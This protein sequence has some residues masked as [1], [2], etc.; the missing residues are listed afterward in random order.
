MHD[1]WFSLLPFLIVIPIAIWTKQVLPGLIAG[2]LLGS[3]LAEPTL[4]GGINQMLDC[5]LVNLAKKNNLL[6]II[7]LY[8]FSGLIGMITVAGGIKG[9]AESLVKRIQTRKGSLILTWASTIGTF[10]SPNLRVVTVTPVM[11]AV[12]NRVKMSAQELGFVI[13]TTANPLIALIP[14]ATAFVGY[15]TSVIQMSLEHEG[16]KQDAYALYMQSIPFNFFSIVMLLVG[17]YLSFFHHSKDV[18]IPLKDTESE[19]TDWLDCH[20]AVAKNL[21]SKPFNLIAPLILVIVLSF[22]L[23]WWDGHTK[24]AGF[25]QAF[26]AADT[27]SAMVKALLIT[28]LLTIV[29]L[30]FQGFSLANIMTGFIAS[31]NEL[32]SVI[33]LLAVVWGLTDVSDDLGFSTY[34]TSHLGW[35]PAFFVPPVLFLLGSAISYF[36]GSSWGTWGMLMPLGLS[37]AHASGTPLPVIIGAVFAS[38]TFGSFASPLSDNSI[39]L[40]TIL[41]LPVMQYARYKL[42]PALIAAAISTL[43]Y[44]AAALIF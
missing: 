17:L 3:Y 12:L 33:L 32:M 39:T 20:P 31:G 37:M 34:I 28:V 27:L 21:P 42:K 41:D 8:A 13:E 5:L 22:I 29:M 24:T 30:L 2:L 23:T 6:I 19:Q 9:F 44:A 14:I 4:L 11:K 40:C 18:T 7:F 26:I 10:T 38:G 35:I 36:I 43:I 15:M 25:F 16:V 1:G